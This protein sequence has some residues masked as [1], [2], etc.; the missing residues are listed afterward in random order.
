MNFAAAVIVLIFLGILASLGSALVHLVRG[1]GDSRRTAKAL[2]IRIGMSAALFA[3][4]FLLYA[5]GLIR[6]HGLA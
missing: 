5:A 4:L 1:R 2:T 6:P 3:L